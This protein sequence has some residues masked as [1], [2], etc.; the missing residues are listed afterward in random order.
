MNIY[1]IALTGGPCAGKTT[2]LK[3]ITKLLQEDGY[4]VITIP[5]TATYLIANG[6]PP[7]ASKEHSIKFQNIVLKTQIQKEE[8]ALTY[9]KDTL[10]TEP[11]FFKDKK[12]IIIICDRGIMDN[13]AYLCQNEFDDLINRHNL[14]ELEILYSY[15][16]VIDLISL[17][18]TNKEMY[19]L[20]GIRY[21]TP[22]MAALRDQ[23]TSSAWLLHPNLNMIMP[24]KKIEDKIN[25]IYNIIK[26]NLNQIKIPD[27]IETNIIENDITL[28]Q[29]NSK[30]YTLTTYRINIQ[31]N[32]NYELT[33]INYKNH[34]IY[35]INDIILKKEEYL[36]LLNLGFLDLIKEETIT[37]YIKDGYRY[38]IKK[39]NNIEDIVTKQNNKILKKTRRIN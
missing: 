17:A 26:L 25:T 15:N 14:N 34:E 13:R 2:V 12:G 35:M 28:N 7:L 9:C 3:E 20:D 38:S 30:T 36:S 16:L 18:T 10:E 31:E 11:T 27:K 22:E 8:L 33:K 37:N 21:E 19:E 32:N 1:K 6:T 23:I 29:N 39:E 4:H 5:E 24:T